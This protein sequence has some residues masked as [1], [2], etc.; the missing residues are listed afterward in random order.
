LGVGVGQLPPE[1][2]TVGN[3]VPDEHV[4]PPHAALDGVQL[5]PPV[6]EAAQGP[7]PPHV[8]PRVGAPVGVHVPTVATHESHVPPH[9]VLQHTLSTQLPLMHSLPSVPQPV[10]FPHRVRMTT[11]PAHFVPFLVKSLAFTEF[12]HA[13]T[14]EVTHPDPGACHEKVK[15]KS[16]ISAAGKLASSKGALAGVLKGSLTASVPVPPA[17]DPMFPVVL[18]AFIPFLLSPPVTLTEKLMMP[19]GL[20]HHAPLENDAPPVIDKTADE[21]TEPPPLWHPCVQPLPPAE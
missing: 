15:V 12:T 20:T 5:S 6:H 2:K 4:P 14:P 17:N 13:A 19:L 10:P 16:P 18:K 21:G 7:E 3:A 11:S 1:Q 9:A 8:R